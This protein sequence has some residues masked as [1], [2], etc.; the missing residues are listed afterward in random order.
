MG[1][2]Q[3]PLN[4]AAMAVAPGMTVEEQKEYI[5]THMDSDLQ[6]TLSDAGAS[7]AAQVAIARR[8]GSV[9]K[10]NAIA[11]D[12]AQMRTACLQDFAIGMGTPD[13][14]AEVAAIV[15][16]WE[17]A[18]VFQQRRLNFVLRLRYLANH[19]SYRPTRDR[20]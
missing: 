18:K 15:A 16:A 20:L 11:V 6:F 4:V 14:R 1:T 17:V 3:R 2:G 9:R 19:V 12:R 7:T 10:F 5:A 13:E 8:F